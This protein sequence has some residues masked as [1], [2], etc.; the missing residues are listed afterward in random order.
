MNLIAQFVSYVQSLKQY[1]LQYDCKLELKHKAFL[2][3]MNLKSTVL[4]KQGVYKLLADS[5][6]CI[7]K[8]VLLSS[9]S[10]LGVFIQVV[11]IFGYLIG[12]ILINP[13]LAVFHV[14]FS[15]LFV[16]SKN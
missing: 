6:R 3:I 15:R 5:N 7:E 12:L 8:I 16:P 14:I 11:S 13:I 4:K 9:P 10:V 2:H 1:E